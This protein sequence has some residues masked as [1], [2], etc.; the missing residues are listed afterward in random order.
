MVEA[1]GHPLPF[2]D[3]LIVFTEVQLYYLNLIKPWSCC[4]LCTVHRGIRLAPSLSN[5]AVLCLMEMPVQVR[6]AMLSHPT[7][8]VG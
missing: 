4:S 5:L 2:W 1:A 8:R 7:Q 6:P 3:C